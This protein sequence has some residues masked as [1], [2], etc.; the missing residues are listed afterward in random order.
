MSFNHIK[1]K[2][3]S[4]G[5]KLII[6]RHKPFMFL[7]GRKAKY[8]FKHFKLKISLKFKF[9]LEKY[10]NLQSLLNNGYTQEKTSQ[11]KVPKE[12]D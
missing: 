9:K 6:T 1:I 11:K 10:L 5:F 4:I 2:V 8:Y 12:R 7:R 3:I